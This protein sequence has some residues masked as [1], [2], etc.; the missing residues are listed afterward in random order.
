[1]DILS[2]LAWGH[3]G[4]GTWGEQTPGPSDIQVLARTREAGECLPA[5]PLTPLIHSRG[6]FPPLSLTQGPSHLGTPTP[7]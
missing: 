6:Q 4:Q 2:L 7:Y 1:M 3:L 5:T